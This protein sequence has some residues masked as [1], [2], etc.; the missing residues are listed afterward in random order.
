MGSLLARVTKL[1]RLPGHKG[2]A[3]GRFKVVW[4]TSATRGL[5]YD[6]R[7][8][9]LSVG[10]AYKTRIIGAKTA[11]GTL[12]LGGGTFAFSVRVRNTRTKAVAAWSAPVISNS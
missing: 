2:S 5:V 4:A 10:G 3:G 1:T 12:K 9:N 11:S 8:R 7:V 6:V